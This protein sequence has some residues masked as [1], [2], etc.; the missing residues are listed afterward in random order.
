MNSPIVVYT[1]F[2][3][4]I[5]KNLKKKLKKNWLNVFINRIQ[6]YLHTQKIT[7]LAKQRS[8]LTIKCKRDVCVLV[9][10]IEY[11]LSH[12]IVS[13]VDVKTEHNNY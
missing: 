13:L 12:F 10:A 6:A 2:Y 7:G 1:N 8:E 3:S 4:N 5:L 9:W 11:M